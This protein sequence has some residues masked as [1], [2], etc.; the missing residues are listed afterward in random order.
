MNPG[1]VR[2][3]TPALTSRS[4]QE[5]DFV[6]VAEF[7]HR[8]VQIATK[9]QTAA[10]SKMIKDFVQQLSANEEVKAALDQLKADVMAFAKR[11]PMPGFDP[12]TIKMSAVK[13][14]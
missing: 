1:G 4:F 8:A 12:A 11:F 2:L 10:G 3:G 7:L 6:K 5:Q 13:Q 9:A 14:A